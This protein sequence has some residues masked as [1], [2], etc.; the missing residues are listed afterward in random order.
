MRNDY[1]SIGFSVFLVLMTLIFTAVLELNK[2]TLTGYV[3]LLILAV[4]ALGLNF[5]IRKP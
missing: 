3:L 2:N 4:A 1:S 5:S